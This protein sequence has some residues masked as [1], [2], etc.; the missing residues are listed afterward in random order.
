[1]IPK[2][3]TNIWCFPCKTLVAAQPAEAQTCPLCG[4]TNI[5][6]VEDWRIVQDRSTGH[7]SILDE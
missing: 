7:F 1:M 6:T 5:E 4:S 2:Q 3:R